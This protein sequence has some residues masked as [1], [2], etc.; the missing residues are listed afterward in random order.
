M[1]DQP[2]RQLI[3]GVNNLL[4]VIYSQVAV[5]RAEG[6]PDAAHQA[7]EFIEQAAQKTEQVVRQ[8]RSQPG[9]GADPV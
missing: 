9:E 6:T 2:T 8:L 7:L 1:T 3:H 4:A 5:A